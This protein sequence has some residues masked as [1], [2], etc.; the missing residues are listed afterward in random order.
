MKEYLTL[1]N[2][3]S[4]CETVLEKSRFIA[5]CRGIDNTQ[6]ATT[7]IAEIRKKHYDATHNCYA[8]VFDE[9]SKCSDD[10]E[11]QGTAGVP[12]CEAIK[13]KGLNR[14]CVVVTR[15]FG[16]IKLGA[17][18]LTRA[19]RSAASR[20]LDSSA[21]IKMSDCIRLTVRTDY[22]YLKPLQNT[23]RKRAVTVN[24]VFDRSV[25]LDLLILVE[26][27]DTILNIVSEITNGSAII[28][29]KERTLCLYEE[30]S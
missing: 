10:G 27:H 16:G 17:G 15:Y 2:S 3:V 7:F 20:V 23:L 5:Y 24:T 14:V 26:M 9:I 30:N 22:C 29:V 18:G 1:P 11:P 28:E 4:V 19:Y 21:V 25:Q 13:F 6:D 8:Y 12:I